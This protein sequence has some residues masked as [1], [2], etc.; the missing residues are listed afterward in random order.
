MKEIQWYP[1]HMDKALREMRENL[2]LVDL[3]LELV[4][5]R[6]PESSRNPELS[7]LG[8][9]KQRMILLNKAD[10]ADPM[11]TE[12]WLAWYRGEG[13][14]CVALDGRSGKRKE[15][16][17]SVMDQLLEEKRTRDQARGIR[18]RPVRAMVVGIPNVGKSTVI[19]TFAGKAVTKTGNRP[20]VTRGKQWIRMG[21]RIELLDTPG[22]LWPRFEDR[23]VGRRLAFLGSI[24]G[25]LL[26]TEELA[27][28]LA[29]E[30]RILSP[31][32]FAA[33]YGVEEEGET[34]ELLGRIA[35]ARNLLEKGGTASLEK[36]AYLVLEDFRKGRLGRITLELPK[37][38]D[39]A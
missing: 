23:A 15:A 17:L 33:R 32:C 27:G 25:E 38:T 21:Q 3:I 8:Q 2:K 30:L 31:G 12:R 24:R 35:E 18:R 20:G 19:N 9:G 26:A 11:A 7:S 13:Y 36:A 1:G 6:A 10:L 39:A 4:D 16:I 14:G 37:P 5:A 29:E 34:A 28:E 22:V